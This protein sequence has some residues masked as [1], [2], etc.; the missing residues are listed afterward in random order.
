MTHDHTFL[1]DENIHGI[2]N[3]NLAGNGQSHGVKY[4]QILIF[5]FQLQKPSLLDFL[6]FDNKRNQNVEPIFQQRN[7]GVKIRMNIFFLKDRARR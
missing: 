4:K 7:S 3:I 2:L 1:L 6:N 5:E